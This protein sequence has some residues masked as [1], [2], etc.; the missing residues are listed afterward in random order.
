MLKS[1]RPLLMNTVDISMKEG[2]L[3]NAL[4]QIKGRE[5]RK[6]PL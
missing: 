2:N 6:T 3:L 4:Y 5:F 1:Q